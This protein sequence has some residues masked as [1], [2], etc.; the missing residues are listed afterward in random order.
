MTNRSR[1]VGRPPG[2]KARG[3]QRAPAAA[4]P[5]FTHNDPIQATGTSNPSAHVRLEQMLSQ[6][7]QRMMENSIHLMYMRRDIKTLLAPSRTDVTERGSAGQSFIRYSLATGAD[8][9]KMNDSSPQDIVEAFQKTGGIWKHIA[10][11]SHRGHHLNLYP[12]NLDVL[13]TI[14]QQQP[15]IRHILQLSEGCKALPELYRVK[16]LKLEYDKNSLEKPNQYCAA[17]SELNGV[18]I[19]KAYWG[20]S[21]LILSLASSEDALRLYKNKWVFLNG[22]RG[23]VK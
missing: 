10:A 16:V 6:Q 1:A 18:K 20:H 22:K 9:V 14:Q 2:A 7:S 3:R 12:N 15:E 13:E 8:C 17:W 11:V 23:T 4:N 19:I 5:S 21:Q